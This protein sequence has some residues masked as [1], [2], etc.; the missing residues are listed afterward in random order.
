MGQNFS[1]E[2]KLSRV[3]EVMLEV[4][5]KR[6]SLKLILTKLYH[7]LNLKKCQDIV[8]GV[9]AK[10]IKGIS[11]GEKRRL[12]FATEIITNPGLL[13]CDEPTRYLFFVKNMKVIHKT[14]YSGLDSFMAQAVVEC[15]KALALKGK[16]MICIIHQ[17]SSDIFQMFDRLCLLAEGRM[18][19]FGDLPQANNYFAKYF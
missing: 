15:M 12:A 6:N 14:N 8:I 13:F 18:A 4:Y 9:E 2:E 3:E 1:E 17:P 19:Y 5:H 11:G 7:Q 16:T 10:N